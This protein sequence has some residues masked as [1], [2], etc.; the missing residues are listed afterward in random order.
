MGSMLGIRV[1]NG[2]VTTS[3]QYSGLSRKKQ[4]HHFQLFLSTYGMVFP[5]RIGLDMQLSILIP[6]ITM[7]PTNYPVVVGDIC[8]LLPKNEFRHLG[9]GYFK[10]WMNQTQCGQG[11][12]GHWKKDSVC[13]LADS[14]SM[15]TCERDFSEPSDGPR[16]S[17]I[18]KSRL[19]LISHNWT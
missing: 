14:Q 17:S 5:G 7:S 13:P 10:S 16:N 8:H 15:W 4:S 19:D 9:I 2:A 6:T 1:A 12:V 3:R 18:T 11:R